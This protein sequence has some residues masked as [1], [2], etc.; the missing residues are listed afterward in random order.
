MPQYA[1]P[2]AIINRAAFTGAYSRRSD[3]YLDALQNAAYPLIYAQSLVQFIIRHVDNQF[4]IGSPVTITLGIYGDDQR[5]LGYAYYGLVR[6]I[7]RNLHHPLKPA[8][9]TIIVE[10]H[11]VP[12][13]IIVWCEATLL[14]WSAPP[15]HIRFVQPHAFLEKE[16]RPHPLCSH[17]RLS[18]IH[19]PTMSHH[20]WNMRYNTFRNGT[21]NPPAIPVG[22]YPQ[23]PPRVYRPIAYKLWRVSPSETTSRIPAPSYHYDEAQW[24]WASIFAT[25]YY[26]RIGLL[27][28]SDIVPGITDFIDEGMVPDSHSYANE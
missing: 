19:F 13:Q 18:I 12:G 11:V 24:V 14:L 27:L 23:H 4:V 6:D 15:S 26:H 9:S 16:Y 7:R 8:T 28:D 22:Y 3:E 5:G 21:Y 2:N 20:A 1:V 17:H 10:M 25:E